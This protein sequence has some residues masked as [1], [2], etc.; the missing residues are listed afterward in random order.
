[1]RSCFTVFCTDF[2]SASQLREKVEASSIAKNIF[3]RVSNGIV[4][5]LK[6]HEDILEMGA[7][8]HAS[9]KSSMIGTAFLSLAHSKAPCFKNEVICIRV[10]G[11][12]FSDQSELLVSYSEISAHN[13]SCAKSIPQVYK[14]PANYEKAKSVR[15][16]GLKSEYV[17][18]G[19]I[20]GP[21]FFWK[22]KGGELVRV[23]KADTRRVNFID[24]YPHT[25]VLASWT[26]PFKIITKLIN[27]YTKMKELELSCV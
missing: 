18:S 7:H 26:L 22:K 15:F 27:S 21:I 2:K 24:P 11:M 19:S 4:D 23:M 17:D 1:M 12:A 5:A 9:E 8:S 3:D 16:F 25:A 6:D 13:E 10:N 14:G 20:Y